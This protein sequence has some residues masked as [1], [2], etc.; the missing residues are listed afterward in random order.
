MTTALEISELAMINDM[1]LLDVVSHNLANANTAGFKRDIAVSTGFEDALNSQLINLS[2]SNGRGDRQLVPTL[3][4]LVDHSSGAMKHTDNPLDLVIE[5]DAFFELTHSEGAL[6]SRQGS[7]S[8]GSD[9][10]LESLDGMVVNGLEGEILLTGNEVTVDSDGSVYEAGEFAGTL[11]LVS[12]ENVENL[13]KMG[14]GLYA[15]NDSAVIRPEHDSSVRQGFRETSNVN[16]MEEMVQMMTTLRH[17]E[18][19]SKVLKGYDDMI[20]TAISTIAEF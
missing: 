7:F 1:R 10:R 19:T 12:F 4:L 6:Y 11:K 13:R 17:F 2:G 16:A 9:G 5:G 15:S 14:N 18:T 20:G 3:Q 8:V